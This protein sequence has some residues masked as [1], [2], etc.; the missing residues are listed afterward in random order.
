MRAYAPWLKTGS[1]MIGAQVGK[2][3]ESK[4]PKY[5]V[6]RK[7]HGYFG[8]RTHTVV[9]PDESASKEQIMKDKPYLL[10]DFGHLPSSLAVGMLGMPGNTAYF[11]FMDI[12]KP[13]EGETAVVSTAAGAVGMHVGQLAKIH[14][15][16]VI[17]I[18]G[19]DAKC[20][21]VVDDLGF[22]HAI[23]YKTQDVSAALKEAAPKGFDCYFDNVGGNISTSVIYQMKLGG[24]IAVCG[25]TSSYNS[26]SLP[27]TS[28]LQPAIVFKQLRME[29]FVVTRYGDRWFE[30]IE[31]NMGWI[32][33]GKL[34]Y[35]E[36]VTH[37][38][39]N[40]Y[41]AFLGLLRGE[42][43]GKAVVKA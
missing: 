15:L 11:G 41:N 38:F 32:K 23:N 36:T 24:R 13:Q 35:R 4:H 3:L 40:M 10:P 21:W 31:K 26:P 37:G 1:T 29:G 33:E 27:K 2:I 12:C 7:I 43:I 39:E 8:W 42:N 19:S 5:P 6:D 25:S 30:G 18:T 9:N 14:G 17:G 20:K 16:Q 22:D 34:K 28:I